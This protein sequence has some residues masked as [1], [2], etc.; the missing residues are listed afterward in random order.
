ML[1]FKLVRGGAF[2][3][4]AG[5]TALLVSTLLAGPSLGWLGA[6]LTWGGLA[7]AITLAFV[8]GVGRLDELKGDRRSR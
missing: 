6:S 1:W 3:L 8:V 2:A 5:L 4:G 7:M